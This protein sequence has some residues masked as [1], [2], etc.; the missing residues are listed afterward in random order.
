[1]GADCG[2]GGTCEICLSILAS[3]M[4]YRASVILV[5]VERSN[6]KP[7]NTKKKEKGKKG[8]GKKEK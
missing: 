8:A 4:R 7:T 3:G 6:P 2:C 1:M 5:E